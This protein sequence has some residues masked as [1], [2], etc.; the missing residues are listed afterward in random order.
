MIFESETTKKKK[1]MKKVI[2]P[3]LSVFFLASCAELQQATKQV[4]EMQT[5]GSGIGQTQIANA[6]KEALEL[7]VSKQVVNLTKTNGFY[8]NSL[9][10]IPV[11]QELQKVEKAL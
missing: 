9:V 6:L 10:K 7:G 8:N 5:E 1:F 11:P 4:S 2:L 3:I